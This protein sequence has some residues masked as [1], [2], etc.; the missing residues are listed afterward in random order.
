MRA[1]NNVAAILF[2]GENRGFNFY[3][4]GRAF[5]V[6]SEIQTSHDSGIDENKSKQQKSI[7]P[8]PGLG[9]R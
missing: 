6:S 8:K 9:K 4:H 5:P 7:M 3:I 1:V 2:K